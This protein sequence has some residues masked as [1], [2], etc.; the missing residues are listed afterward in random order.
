MPQGGYGDSYTTV[1]SN[2]KEPLGGIKCFQNY[3]SM[4]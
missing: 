3:M 1:S 4:R 2:A